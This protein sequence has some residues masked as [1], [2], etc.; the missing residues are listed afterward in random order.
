MVLQNMKTVIKSFYY[1]FQI[2]SIAFLKAKL[3]DQKGSH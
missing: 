1:S 3:T 2:Q